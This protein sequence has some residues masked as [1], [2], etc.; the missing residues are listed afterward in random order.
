M[1]LGEA[2]HLKETGVVIGWIQEFFVDVKAVGNFFQIAFPL[3][4]CQLDTFLE[5]VL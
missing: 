5:S 2:T 1:L 3:L 4:T